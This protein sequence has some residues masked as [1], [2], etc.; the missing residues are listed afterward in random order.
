M[1][2]LSV[3]EN[4]LEIALRHAQEADARQI[5]N[6]YLVIGQLASIVDDSVQFY[7]DLIA[8]DTIAEQACLH[9]RRIPVEF[10]CLSC[11][12]RF[13][14]ADGDLLCEQCGSAQMIILTGEE[15]FI[16]AIDIET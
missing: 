13:H 6:I 1:H 15:F 4:I 10:E 14:P 2:E 9:F 3:T 8:K 11:G 5:V 7:W 16:E 12:H